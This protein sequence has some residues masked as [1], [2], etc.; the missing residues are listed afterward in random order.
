SSYIGAMV[1]PV[2]D[3]AQKASDGYACSA[4]SQYALYNAI[5]LIQQGGGCAFTTK[6]TNAANAG[7]LGIIFYMN[8]SGSPTPVE[9]QDSSGN[10]PLYGPI[11]MVSQSDGQNLKTYIDA[12]AG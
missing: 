8:T 11:V 5:A 7:A 4:L 12:H 10:I 1:L 9:T 6:A 3:A 2:V